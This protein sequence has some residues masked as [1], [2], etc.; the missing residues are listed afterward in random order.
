MTVGRKAVLVLSSEV[1]LETP[2]TVVGTV[3]HSHAH[4]FTIM[5]SQA[6][7]PES[8]TVGTVMHSY[9]SHSPLIT[10]THS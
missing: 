9:H 2:A 6:Q 7:F 10:V 4:S 5:H 3:R 8:G 1:D